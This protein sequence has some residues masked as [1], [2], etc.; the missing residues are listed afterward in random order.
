[1]WNRNI[2]I[3]RHHFSL[4]GMIRNTYFSTFSS[5]RSTG[6]LSLSEGYK[7]KVCKI[8]IEEKLTSSLSRACIQCVE[9]QVFLE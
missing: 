5:L 3:V 7:Y 1:M 2:T 6:D 9:Y 4:D 8:T